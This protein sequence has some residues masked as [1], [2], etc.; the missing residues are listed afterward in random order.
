VSGFWAW[1]RDRYVWMPGHWARPPRG[2]AVWVKPRWE[3]RGGTYVFIAGSW[4]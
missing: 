3:R 2:G 1:D 4:R